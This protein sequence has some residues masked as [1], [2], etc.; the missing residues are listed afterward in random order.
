LVLTDDRTGKLLVDE[1]E[2]SLG[3][4]GGLD[5]AGLVDGGVGHRVEGECGG[6]GG[7]EE[8]WIRRMRRKG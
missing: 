3:V 5:E 6:G 7:G 8:E 2:E 4:S 1:V